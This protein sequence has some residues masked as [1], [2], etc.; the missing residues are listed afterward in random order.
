[1]LQDSQSPDAKVPEREGKANRYNQ[2]LKHPIGKGLDV[3]NIINRDR[4][5]KARYPG[6]SPALIA[7]A[8]AFLLPFVTLTASFAAAML[9]FKGVLGASIPAQQCFGLAIIIASTASFIANGLELHSISAIIS[10]QFKLR[11]VFITA[12]LSFLLLL[13][14]LYLLKIGDEV[15][16]GWIAIW[17]IFT[18]GLLFL[19]R[20]GILIWARVLRAEDRLL[21]RISV[22]GAAEMIE[23]VTG[24]L[25]AKDRNL[26]LAGAFSDSHAD[27]F[28]VPAQG[29][30][31]EL[32]EHAQNG[33]CDRIIVALP[34]EEADA[35]R[36]ALR[37]LEQL[38]IDV[39]LA[40]DAITLPDSVGGAGLILVDVQH[41]PLTERDILVKAVMDYALSAVAFAIFAPA[42]VAIAVA[43]SFDSP[44]P[45][46]FVQQRHGL[47]GRVIRVLKFRTMSVAEDGPVIV[48]AVRGDK[49]VTRVG[50][51][52]RRTSLDELPQL[53]NVLR[54]EL[55]LVGP[56]PHAVA[57]NEAY[58]QILTEYATR[59]KVKPGITGLAQVNGLRGGTKTLEEMRRR[60]D[61][62][63]YYIK[64]W[65]VWLDIEILARTFAVPFKSPNA[66]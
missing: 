65:S 17:Y 47:K 21:Q 20:M 7:E 61:L 25:F 33:A 18:L 27:V 57:H 24:A 52:L 45:I 66:Y 39:Q 63:L 60:V 10:G 51:L 58:A 55:S 19:A 31:K 46:F 30:L 48:Q 41:R 14:L 37:R 15:S 34:S 5:H 28:G 40:P 36:E 16:R 13:C 32:V 9:Y 38:P 3:E 29:G 11:E 50:Q 35:I 1:M 22:Y 42:M 6:V 23:R 2:A 59:H 49:R 4:E 53:I 26:V 44:G 56:R 54:G 43:I 64:N 62:D 8:Q 12:S